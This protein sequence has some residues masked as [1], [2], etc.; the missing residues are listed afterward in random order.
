MD[1]KKMKILM[2]YVVLVVVGGIMIKNNNH[3]IELAIP[4]SQDLNALL[5]IFNDINVVDPNGPPCVTIYGPL[6]SWNA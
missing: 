1:G 5:Y 6:N 2:K 3:A 4:I